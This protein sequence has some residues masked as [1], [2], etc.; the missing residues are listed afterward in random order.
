MMA[1]LALPQEQE[2]K[3]PPPS[4]GKAN[5]CLIDNYYATHS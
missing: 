4:Y 1:Y 5:G 3:L 2:P